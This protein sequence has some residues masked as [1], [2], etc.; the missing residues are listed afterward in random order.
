MEI[1]RVVSKPSVKGPED[2]VHGA[3]RVDPLFD[4]N[5][6]R[7]AAAANVTFRAG[8]MDSLHTHPRGQTLIITSGSGWVQREVGI[9]FLEHPICFRHYICELSDI[10]WFLQ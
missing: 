6:S 10:K 4:P 8:C 9:V 3:V 1:T 5:E 7:R 2:L